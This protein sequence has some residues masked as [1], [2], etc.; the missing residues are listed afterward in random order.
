MGRPSKLTERQWADIERRHLAGESV[1]K[2]AKEYKIGIQT[3]R[4]RVTVRTNTIKTLSNQLSAVERK[5]EEL[6]LAVQVSVRTLT[7]RLKS[8]SEHAASAAEYGMM[9]SHRL[10]MLAHSEVQKIDEED[11]LKSI[12]SLKGINALTE[13]SNKSAQIG[14]TLLASNAKTQEQ[15]VGDRVIRVIGGLPDGQ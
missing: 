1:Q 7:D 13:L 12:E 3:V 9:T 6:P 11:P 14:L 4:D 10:S 5:I 8:I 15:T 2:L